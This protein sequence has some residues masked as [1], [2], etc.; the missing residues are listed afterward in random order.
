MTIDDDALGL[1]DGNN[2]TRAE[3]GETIELDISVGNGGQTA[4]TA[5]TAA[6]STSDP[7]IAIADSTEYLGDLTGGS[8]QQYD[9]AFVV[10]IADTCPTLDVDMIADVAVAADNRPLEYVREGPQSGTLSDVP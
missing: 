4:A 9:A 7:Y 6:V 10:S 3:A 5:V 2:N 1:S 8:V